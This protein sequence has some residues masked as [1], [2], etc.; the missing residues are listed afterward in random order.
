MMLHYLRYLRELGKKSEVLGLQSVILLLMEVPNLTVMELLDVLRDCAELF[1]SSIARCADR[2]A[3]EDILALEQV[4]EGEGCAEFR[5]L[6]G[7]LRMSE[8][9]GIRRA[10]SEIAEDRRFFREQLRLDTEQEL[11]KKAANAQVVAFFPMMFLLFAYL[12]L[13]F[14]AVSLDQ[15]GQ[16]FEEM[17]QIRYF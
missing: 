6:M 12:I 16:I 1:Q 4:Q 17:E 7:R 3:S 14:L 15:M 9:V 10:F 11:K 5:Q 2:Y 13:P 8:Q